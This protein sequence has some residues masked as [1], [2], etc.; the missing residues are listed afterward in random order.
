MKTCAPHEIILCFDK[1]ELAGEDKYFNKLWNI[2]QKYKNYCNFSFVYDREDLLDLKDSPTD[3]GE[4][5][6]I[7]LIGKRVIVK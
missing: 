7:K 3:K 1:E 6:F 5:T 4:E 2:C